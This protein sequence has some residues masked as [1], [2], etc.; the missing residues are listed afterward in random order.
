MV[1]CGLYPVE[2]DDFA[3]LRDA[4]EKLRLNDASFTYEP[5]TSGALGFGANERFPGRYSLV[6][7]TERLSDLLHRA[8]GLTSEAYPDGVIFYRRQDRTG[9]VGVDLARAAICHATDLGDHTIGDG[10]VSGLLGCAGA[11]DDSSSANYEIGHSSSVLI[12]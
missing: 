7:K 4:L 6:A 8:G 11:V 12:L 3:D 9:R 10:D 1:F 2:G 5:E